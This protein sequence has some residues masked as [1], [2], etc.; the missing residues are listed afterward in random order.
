MK[1]KRLEIHSS[2]FG[3]SGALGTSF[4]GYAR[5][6]IVESSDKVACN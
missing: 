2:S 5:Q 4:D 3:D 6:K 1:R